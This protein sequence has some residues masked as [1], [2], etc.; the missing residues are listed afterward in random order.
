[1]NRHPSL[2]ALLLVIV[3]CTNSSGPVSECTP[4][5]TVACVTIQDFTFSSASL[6]IQV[7]TTV[8]WTNNGP[9]AHTTTNDAGA[10]NSGTIS[11]PSGGGAYGGGGRWR[12]VSVYVRR[13]GYIRLPLRP[14]SPIL[15]AVRRVHGDDHRYPVTRLSLVV[16]RSASLLENT[17][18]SADMCWPCGIT[19]RELYHWATVAWLSSNKLR[20]DLRRGARPGGMRRLGRALS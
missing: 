1:M 18:A 19:N 9:S 10:W 12:V 8:K 4:S 2:P 20:R 14:P 16:A 13:A 6:T 17:T 11:A 7:G 5:A 15:V 3:A